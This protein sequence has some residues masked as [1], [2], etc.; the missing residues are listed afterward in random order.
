MDAVEAIRTRR[1]IPRLG[2]EVARGTVDE[3]LAAAL[4]APNHR[5]T[6]PWR[7]SVVAGAARECLG[8]RWAEIAAAE[9]GLP[10][11]ARTKFIDSE[12]RRLL[13]APVVIFASTRTDANPEVATE[14]FAATAAAIENLL[15]AAH[16]RGLGAMW[17]TGR[18]AYHP[19]MVGL[20]ELDPLDR[21]V[22]IVYLGQLIEPPPAAPPAA[23]AAAIRWLNER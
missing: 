5:L 2:G 18:M 22:G 19:A 4:C 3:L 6:R 7:F 1:S 11:D 17:R 13:R 23:A 15:L 16:A 10:A 14:D 9:R 12:A 20:L 8:R 21:I